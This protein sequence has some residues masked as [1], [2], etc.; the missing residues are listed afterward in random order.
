M[1]DS[2]CVTPC[3]YTL[4]ENYTQDFVYDEASIRAYATFSG[5]SNPM[6][7]D[8][9]F[10]ETTQFGGLIASAAHYSSQMMGAAATFLTQRSGSLGLEFSFV[11]KR[12]VRAGAE[13]TLTWRVVEITAKPRLHGHIVALEGTLADSDGAVAVL[14]KCKALVMPQSAMRVA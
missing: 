10:A 8:A 11:F 14:A 5:D 3:A 1:P 12:A 7:H 6:H 2:Q 4:D 9:A 13:L